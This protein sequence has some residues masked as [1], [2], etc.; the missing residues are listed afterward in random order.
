MK[1]ICIL[2][3]LCLFLT[4]AGCGQKG[5]LVVPQPEQSESTAEQ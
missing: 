4:L 5:P 3:A 2:C 1:H